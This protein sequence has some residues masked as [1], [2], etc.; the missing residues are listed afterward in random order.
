M[1]VRKALAAKCVHPAAINNERH[2]FWM[3]FVWKY[4]IFISS[5]NQQFKY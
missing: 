5:V 2:L 4:E 1:A 3:P